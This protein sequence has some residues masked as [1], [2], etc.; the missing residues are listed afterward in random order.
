MKAREVLRVAIEKR[1]FDD[2]TDPVS[3]CLGVLKDLDALIESQQHQIKGYQSHLRECEQVA[4]KILGYPWFMDDQAN[5]PGSTEKDG[6]CVGEHVGETIV[7][8]LA[9]AY[10]ALKE[11]VEELV[12]TILNEPEEHEK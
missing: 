5:F 1:L 3:V 8:E 6:V 12:S 4:G 2:D 10:I 7:Q 9:D 11:R